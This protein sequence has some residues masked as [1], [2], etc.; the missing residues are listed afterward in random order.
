MTY[1]H[2]SNHTSRHNFH[3]TSHHSSNRTFHPP[4]PTAGL[5]RAYGPIVEVIDGGPKFLFLIAVSPL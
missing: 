3:R 2:S 1:H 5:P 4:K